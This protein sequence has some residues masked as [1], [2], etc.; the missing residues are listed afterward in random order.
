[1]SQCCSVPLLITALFVMV[2][3]D[4]VHVYKTK[5]TRVIT[6]TD[7]TATCKSYLLY[8]LST[9]FYLHGVTYSPDIAVGKVASCGLH[10]IRLSPIHWA[11]G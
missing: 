11:A 7:H 2:N 8:V 10:D 6:V 5:P 4:N 3:S 9:A 1:V